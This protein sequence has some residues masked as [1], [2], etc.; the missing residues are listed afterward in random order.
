MGVL[1]TRSGSLGAVGGTEKSR[2][3]IS[4][5]SK[6]N[7][8]RC[9]W[10]NGKVNH[11]C[12]TGGGCAHGP[13]FAYGHRSDPQPDPG[14]PPAGDFQGLR[15]HSTSGSGAGDWNVAGPQDHTL[16]HTDS[17][18]SAIGGRHASVVHP[19]RTEL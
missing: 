5:F 10:R 12:L 6:M 16:G 13:A 1:L 2:A 3:L 7:N 15:E 4:V 19:Y 17:R 14:G 11:E 18:C 8:A 9:K